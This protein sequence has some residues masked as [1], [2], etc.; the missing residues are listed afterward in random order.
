MTVIMMNPKVFVGFLKLNGEGVFANKI[1]TEV[2][3][4]PEFYPA[5]E[6]HHDYFAKNPGQGYCQAV[7]GPKVAKFRKR[8]ESLLKS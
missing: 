8:Y 7:V 1:V 5:E 2:S 6:Y 4:A 3:E